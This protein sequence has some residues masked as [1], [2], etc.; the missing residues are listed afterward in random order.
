MDL[1][2]RPLLRGHLGAL[3]EQHEARPGVVVERAVLIARAGPGE[4]YNPDV[5]VNRL[6]VAL[7]T[8][9]TLGLRE[10]LERSERG[11]RLD[12]RVEVHRMAPLMRP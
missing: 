6:N 7:S 4:R 12:P 5:H 3:A 9:R 1:A 10:L 8:L 11:Y 2:R